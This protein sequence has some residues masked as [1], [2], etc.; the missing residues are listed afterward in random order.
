[1]QERLPGV[2]VVLELGRYLVGE[3]GIYVAEVVDRK[4]SR[5]QTFL[6]TNGGLHHHLAASGNFGQVI[7]KN[8]PVVVGNRV[9]GTERETVTVV[10][11]LCTPLDLLA[12][13]MELARADVGDLIVVFQS[14]AYGLTA[15]PSAFLSHPPCLEVLV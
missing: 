6:I 5:G 4:V 1:M 2:R 9:N 7:R 12:E 15:S 14:G 3:A 8:Y 10:G 13:R 11:P